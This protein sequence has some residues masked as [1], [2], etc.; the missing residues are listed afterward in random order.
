LRSASSRCWRAMSSS[1]RSLIVLSFHRTA[2]ARRSAPKTASPL[3]SYDV[4]LEAL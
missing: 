4:S 3:Q 1:E 2:T